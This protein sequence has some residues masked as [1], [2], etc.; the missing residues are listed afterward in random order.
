MNNQEN[1]V[2]KDVFFESNT[3][4]TPL[5]EKSDITAVKA[6]NPGS[7]GGCCSSCCCGDVYCNKG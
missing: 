3:V 5:H 1:S 4:I 6:Q 7:G 2:S